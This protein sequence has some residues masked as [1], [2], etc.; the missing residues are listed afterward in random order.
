MGRS[1][2]HWLG[3]YISSLPKRTEEEVRALAKRWRGGEVAIRDELVQG[4][5][6]VTFQAVAKYEHH[7]HEELFSVAI[8]TIYEAL[9][10]YPIAAAKREAEEN[11]DNIKAYVT[12][13]VR[14]R[15][16]DFI[17]DS[18]G[19]PSPRRE[20]LRR[21]N[22]VK[23]VVPASVDGVAMV[24][25]CYNDT[26]THDLISRICEDDLDKKIINLRLQGLL[27]PEIGRTLGCSR[28]LVTKRRLLIGGR[29]KAIYEELAINVRTQ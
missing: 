29:L 9:E 21:D 22:D 10:K 13:F 24:D 14:S 23:V 28:Q 12:Q 11:K 4:V 6:S 20:H 17:C 25:D 1:W 15:I 19:V 27:D 16:M 26:D 7:N 2:K 3:S 18:P 8:E 5:M